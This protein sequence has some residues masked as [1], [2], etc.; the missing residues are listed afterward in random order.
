M[1]PLVECVPN[2]SEGRRIQVIKDIIKAIKDVPGNLVLDWQAD[3]DRNR[4][5]VS[6]VGSPEEVME[7]AFQAARR[8]TQLVDINLH[9]GQHPRIGATDVIPFIPLRGVTMAQC[10]DLARE[11]GARIGEDLSIPVY[12]YEEAAAR[13]ERRNLA[14]IRK[15]EYES[16]REEIGYK[17]ERRPDFGPEK[18][19]PTAGAVAIGARFFMIAF[20]VNLNTQNIQLARN[21][22]MSIRESRDFPGIRSMAFQIE[23][24]GIVQVYVTIRNYRT[25]PI[26][27]VFNEIKRLASTAGVKVL[28]SEIIGLLPEEAFQQAAAGLLQLRKLDKN[29]IIEE[30][31]RMTSGPL[32]SMSSFLYD[33]GSPSPF[34]GGGSACALAGSLASVLVSFLARFAMKEETDASIHSELQLLRRKARGLDWEFRNLVQVDAA[35]LQKV[36]EAAGYPAGSSEGKAPG[37]DGLKTLTDAIQV[38]LLTMERARD[39]MELVQSTL[40]MAVMENPELRA[41]AATAV[42]LAHAVL[43]SAGWNTRVLLARLKDSDLVAKSEGKILLIEQEG[44]DLRES[45]LRKLQKART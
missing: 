11:L 37:P 24:R 36:M 8:A 5:V 12:L 21:I 38:R 32:L 30:R 39:A 41:E 25:T 19:H 23:N 40:G 6:F 4:S 18:V 42:L 33:L 15:G 28:D 35:M 17:E 44:D 9:R 1:K 45:I 22:A 20:N 2:F 27:K 29:Q 16:L 13:P 43:Q 31:L 34:P 26:A 3:P 10:V 7:A 14:S